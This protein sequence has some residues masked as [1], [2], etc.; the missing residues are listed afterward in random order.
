MLE[1]RRVEVDAEALAVVDR[2]QRLARGDE[3]VGDLGRVDLERELHALGVEDVDDRREALGELLVAALD[4]GEVVGRERVEHVP[5]RRAGEAGDRR[6]AE[7]R[8]G[9]GGVLELVGGALADALGVAVAPHVGRDDAL[10]AGVDRI[11]DRLA[12]EVVADR[13]DVQA[14]ALEQLAPLAA[15]GVV[16]ERGVD[17]EVVAPAGELEAVEAPG[18]GLRGE[19]GEREVGPLAGEQR[20][21]SW[22]RGAKDMA[23]AYSRAMRIAIAGGGP[24]GL[25]LS[26]LLKRLDPAH[27]VVVY[28]RNAPDD[29]FGFGVVFS[30]ETLAAFEAA[31]P[32]SYAEI[33]RRFV[34][35]SEIDV[36]YRGEV[37]TSGGH[38]FSRARAQAA[39]QHPPDARGRA[40]R[41]AALPAPRCPTLDGD[42]V[43]AADGVNSTLRARYADL[44]AV[45]GPAPGDVRVVRHRRTSSR[46]SRSSSPRPS[47][48]S[49]RSTPIPTATR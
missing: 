25:Y 29:T 23:R 7:P 6:H 35:W 1:V 48:A 49:C 28:E 40:R 39:A 38:G 30:D 14:V 42:L 19:L 36:H 18:A 9:A 47:T 31:D 22:H 45:A 13:P 20:D 43:V 44:P 4:L 27:E 37:I 11:A 3:V 21:G 26:I 12:D 24:G 34:R 41:R 46:R 10:V 15:V 16:G 17:V 5:G 2:V 33:T 8:R 32:E